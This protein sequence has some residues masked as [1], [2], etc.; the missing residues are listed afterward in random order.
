MTNFPFAPV[1]AAG[2]LAIASASAW[3]IFDRPIVGLTMAVIAALATLVVA[4]F[5]NSRRSRLILTAIVAAAAVTTMFLAN[6]GSLPDIFPLNGVTDLVTSR[7]P[8][9]PSAASLVFVGLLAALLG[10]AS[11]AGLATRFPG[12]AAVAPGVI[13]VGASAFFGAPAGPPSWLYVSALIAAALVVLAVGFG[14]PRGLDRAAFGVA[15]LIALLPAIAG[16]WLES[17]RYDPRLRDPQLEVLTQGPS[18]LTLVDEMRSEV[19][20]RTLFTTSA[21]SMTRW[22]LAALTRYDGRVWA[23]PV[24]S[25]QIA[26]RLVRRSDISKI[27]P[28][29]IEVTVADF[30]LRLVPTPSGSVTSL[31][32]ESR[33][34]ANLSTFVAAEPLSSGMTYQVSGSSEVDPALIETA[35]VAAR[36][37]VAATDAIV[38]SSAVSELATAITAGLSTDSARATA[39][40]DY[41]RTGY[42]LDDESAA[43]H[44]LALIE[45]FLLRAKV[46][47]EEQFVAAYG[48]LA[49]SVGLPVRLVAGFEVAPG[50]IEVTTSD[51]HSW[52]EVAFDKIGWIR[53]NPVP[54]E[55]GPATGSTS[56]AAADANTIEVTQRT[57]PTTAP[58]PTDESPAPEPSVIGGRPIRLIL[59]AF[60]LLLP[61]ILVGAI[62]MR[63]RRRRLD[64]L[65][66]TYREQVIG[67]FDEVVDSLVDR[68]AP[69]RTS[70]TDRELV[71]AAVSSQE[72]RQLLA[73]LAVLS[74]EAIYSDHE[75]D[76][77]HAAVARSILTEFE[78][79]DR[80]NRV[81]HFRSR[82][83]T[84]SIR[85]GRSRLRHRR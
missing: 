35:T 64:R 40:A 71:A 77:D 50:A 70:D 37:A 79:N 17:S 81:R 69:V 39:I 43:G 8:T 85:R 42:S 13:M 33:A 60:I 53:M 51:A 80:A 58:P 47:R 3:R 30:A 21:P 31:S 26:G 32:V 11:G 7:W 9:E 72:T 38:P 84:R 44:S 1:A 83:S 5:G 66:G 34:D 23:S 57:T 73:P 55:E 12:P 2:F 74:T 4:I 75:F 76:E 24:V 10:S 19:R 16:V 18:P 61:L 63:K 28:T 46:G 29:D 67:A 59:G 36:S 27:K 56:P 82:L 52:P 78:A 15:G 25:D 22:R 6:D 49:H 68:G 48:L 45:N 54:A 62:V 20:P 41:L 65:S 14:L